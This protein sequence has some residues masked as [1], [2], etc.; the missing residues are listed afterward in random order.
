MP[1]LPMT[2][3]LL[4]FAALLLVLLGGAAWILYGPAIENRG[5][6]DDDEA[7]GTVSP[8]PR[9]TIQSGGTVLTL[10]AA[11]QHNGGIETAHP[12]PGPAQGYLVAYGTVLDAASLTDLENNY[13]DAK[14]K[15]QTADARLA[16]SGA[17]FERA[18]MVHSNP[19]G[20]LHGSARERAGHLSGRSS[21]ARFS[22][23]PADHARR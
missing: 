8:P 6:N 19:P 15:V 13:L 20:H 18:R 1:D 21:C 10:N 5:G 2:R 12:E 22:A 9:V 7:Q 3:R 23:N 4:V 17:A 16:V 14:T 11:T